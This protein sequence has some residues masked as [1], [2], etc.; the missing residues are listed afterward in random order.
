[1]RPTLPDPPA[2]PRCDPGA[3]RLRRQDRG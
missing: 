2:P 1:M 3:G